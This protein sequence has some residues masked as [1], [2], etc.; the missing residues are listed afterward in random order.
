MHF[1]HY[2][3][4]IFYKLQQNIW[5][6]VR[7]SSWNKHDICQNHILFSFIFF[8]QRKT[9]RGR[10]YSILLCLWGPHVSIKSRF[11]WVC[12]YA[13]KNVETVVSVHLFLFLTSF[14]L[15][16]SQILLLMF[17]F[18]CAINQRF[19]KEEG[20]KMHCFSWKS[21]IS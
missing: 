2:W 17:Q 14:F 16:L 9:W 20:K 7:F 13:W 4:D 10:F 11:V 8:T 1:F 15:S 18:V 19:E 21:N 12:I 5:I 6:N 3:K